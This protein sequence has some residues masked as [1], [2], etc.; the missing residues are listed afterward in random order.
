[1]VLR[2]A[3]SLCGVSSVNETNYSY[4]LTSRI[5]GG[6]QATPH[7]YPWQVLLNNQGRFCGG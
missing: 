1:M 7:S 2:R 6:R 5:V 3:S 4:G